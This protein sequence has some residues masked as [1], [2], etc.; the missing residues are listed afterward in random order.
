MSET[1]IRNP[2]SIQ[3]E[4]WKL[5]VETFGQPA[6]QEYVDKRMALEQGDKDK[7]EPN[8][9]PPK[10]DRANHNSPP[11]TRTQYPPN[12]TARAIIYLVDFVLS[13]AWSVISFPSIWQSSQ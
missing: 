5:L 4:A 3:P 11:I 1:K 7:T 8:P 13:Y 6:I 2:L 9:N 10:V 12:N